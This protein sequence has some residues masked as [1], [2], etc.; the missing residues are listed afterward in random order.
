MQPGPVPIEE[1]RHFA[2]RFVNRDD[3]YCTQQA[4]GRFLRVYDRVTVELLARH[5][6]GHVTLSLDAQNSRGEGRW[7]VFDD[8][9]EGLDR[10]LTIRSQL[11]A[12]GLSS[13]C[14]R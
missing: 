4:G 12:W 3:T 8:D 6:L 13:M 1:I 10:L 11:A 14:E 2:G 5:C 7:L 9:G